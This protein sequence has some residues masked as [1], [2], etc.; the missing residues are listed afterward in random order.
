MIPAINVNNAVR[1]GKG[2]KES[3]Q[4]LISSPKRPAP[5]R[6]HVIPDQIT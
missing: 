2:R 1:K 4:P 3:Q 6:S 5:A